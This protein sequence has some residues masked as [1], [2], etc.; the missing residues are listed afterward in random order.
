MVALV[1]FRSSSCN[2]LLRE[3]GIKLTLAPKSQRG[4]LIF[5]SPM[6]QG[7]EKLPGLGCFDGDW[8][9]RTT[10]QPSPMGVT[11]GFSCGCFLER[12]SLKN[13]I[14]EG[15]SLR[16][17][18]KRVSRYIL[19]IVQIWDQAWIWLP[20]KGMERAAD[21]GGMEVTEHSSPLNSHSLLFAL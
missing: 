4:L 1:G 15:A 3:R 19:Q 20:F 8:C 13:L 17:S 21:K 11:E 10:L 9:L 16:A 2:F 7:I 6:E 14:W 5:T 12:S 18:N